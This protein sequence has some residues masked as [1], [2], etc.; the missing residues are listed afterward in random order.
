MLSRTSSGAAV[1]GLAWS[2]DHADDVTTVDPLGPDRFH[3]PPVIGKA[4]FNPAGNLIDIARG[5]VVEDKEPAIRLEEP[6][7]NR[8]FAR[9]I[10]PGKDTDA[11]GERRIEAHVAEICLRQLDG[12]KDRPARRDMTG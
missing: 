1:I 5:L 6:R 11:D 2:C 9:W 4:G 7:K 8:E 3:A 10:A 12:L